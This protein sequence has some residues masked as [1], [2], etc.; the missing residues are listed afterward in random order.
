[1]KKNRIYAYLRVSTKDQN[2]E[3]QKLQ[4]E[5]FAMQNN[6]QINKFV[7]EHISGSTP[8]L[9]KIIRSNIR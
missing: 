6:L 8:L 2:L 9:I 4:I 3:T 1:M 7:E 5:K